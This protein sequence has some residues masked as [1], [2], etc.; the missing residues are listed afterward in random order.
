MQLAPSLSSPSP[1]HNMALR[2]VRWGQWAPVPQPWFIWALLSLL[3][4]VC[5]P[6]DTKHWQSS[7]SG[8]PFLPRHGILSGDKALSKDL[9]AMTRC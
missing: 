2:N 1:S 4:R 3:E 6:I 9:K 5:Q 8:S 7:Q